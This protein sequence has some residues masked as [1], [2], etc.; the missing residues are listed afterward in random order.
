MFQIKI[1]GITQ[2]EDARHGAL[3]RRRRGR[4]QLLR[5]ESAV[6]RNLD[7]PRRLRRSEIRGAPETKLVGVFVN[8]S[9]AEICDVARSGAVAT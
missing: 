4:A 3:V 7:S 1:C 8:A 2:I 9:A 6:H 5:Q